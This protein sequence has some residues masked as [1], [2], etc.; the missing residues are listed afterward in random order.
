MVVNMQQTQFASDLV[1]LGSKPTIG[2]PYFRYNPSRGVG[3]VT[4]V[5]D[6]TFLYYS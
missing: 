2:L 1:L 4:Q 3:V 5:R 6:E